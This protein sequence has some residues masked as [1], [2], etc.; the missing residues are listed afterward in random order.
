MVSRWWPRP[1]QIVQ[2][3]MSS[4]PGHPILID[5]L[6][7]ILTSFSHPHAASHDPTAP[8][9]LDTPLVPSDD[10]TD[11]HSKHVMSVVELT[12][13]GPFTD[14]VLRYLGVLTEGAIRWKDLR[15]LPEEG[16]RVGDVL[17][18]PIT[19]F[20]P[21]VGH[22]GAGEVSDA[23]A[24]VQHGCVLALHSCDGEVADDML[25]DSLGRGSRGSPRSSPS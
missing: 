17:I 4:S 22:M 5:T 11:D 10:D 18:L 21:G 15:S 13:P 23:G 6:R 8:T 9:P 16:M 12:G 24:Y 7:R 19:G 25:A 14:S 2:W 3:S 1:I 20:S